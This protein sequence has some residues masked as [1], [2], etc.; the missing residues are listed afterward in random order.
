[1]KWIVSG[2]GCIFHWGIKYGLL[3][4]TLLKLWSRCF[5]LFEC[6]SWKLLDW[7]G[8]RVKLFQQLYILYYE[9]VPSHMLLCFPHL[10]CCETSLMNALGVLTLGVVPLNPE[11]YWAPYCFHWP[12]V[13]WCCCSWRRRYRGFGW[14]WTA[15][16]WCRKMDF[17][18]IWLG[19]SQGFPVINRGITID[20]I[21]SNK[22][23]SI[24]Q[25]VYW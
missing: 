23:I 21:Y 14:F 7:S 22:G 16:N 20:P 6:M 19:I 1:M 24:F 10:G 13:Y 18:L 12:Q 9:F 17:A 2:K 8:R 5:Q 25:S 11:R 3:V 15:K 4:G